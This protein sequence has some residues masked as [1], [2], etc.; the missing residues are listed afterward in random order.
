MTILII[1]NNIYI[2]I[3][4]VFVNH[5]SL[6]LN[7]IKKYVLPD[8]WQKAQNNCLSSLLKWEE[9]LD[10]VLNNCPWFVDQ[11]NCDMSI[12][13]VLESLKVSSMRHAAFACK[14]YIQSCE[15][16]L[17]DRKRSTIFGPWLLKHNRDKTTGLLEYLTMVDGS[18]KCDTLDHKNHIE[19]IEPHYS[20]S[21]KF[22]ITII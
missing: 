13:E 17:V 12:C 5:L 20:L 18:N 3:Y 11:S 19:V 8:N 9:H 14:S 7:N 4:N 15:Q 1:L 16:F 22:G 6:L 21:D 2:Y 10:P